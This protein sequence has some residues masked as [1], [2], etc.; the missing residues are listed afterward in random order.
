M[1]SYKLVKVKFEV[2]GLQ[3]RVEQFVHKVGVIFISWFLFLRRR[4][5]PYWG[6]LFDPYRLVLLPEVFHFLVWIR[7]HPL[8]QT[9]KNWCSII[10]FS[11]ICSH[12]TD[13]YL[14]AELHHISVKHLSLRLLARGTHT[15][16]H[17]EKKCHGNTGSDNNI[18]CNMNG[19][20]WNSATFKG[21]SLWLSPLSFNFLPFVFLSIFPLLPVYSFFI[22]W[23]R[24]FEM[25][26]S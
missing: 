7:T 24:W 8:G 23:F 20:V 13:L 18:S 22:F 1:C 11:N 12:P 25:Y 17:I 19:K 15:C 5:F 16:T 6:K 10:T 9:N 3:S 2:W 4:D 14:L 21:N 26:S